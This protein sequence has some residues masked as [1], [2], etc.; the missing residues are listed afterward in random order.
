MDILTTR[1]LGPGERTIPPNTD[2]AAKWAEICPPITRR[3]LCPLR[4]LT[5]FLFFSY[6]PSHIG[7]HP[8]LIM[9]TYYY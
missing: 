6:V 1:A 4:K 3:R 9:M 2:P 5:P 8:L 7:L